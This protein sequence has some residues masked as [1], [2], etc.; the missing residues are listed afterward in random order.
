VSLDCYSGQ[1]DCHNSRLLLLPLLR[2]ACREM[3]S[4]HPT[5]ATLFCYTAIL[6][7]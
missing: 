6:T 7:I 4:H 1:W 3:A 5:N 2:A